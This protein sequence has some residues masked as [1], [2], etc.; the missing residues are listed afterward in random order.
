MPRRTEQRKIRQRLARLHPSQ[1]QSAPAHVS[2]TDEFRREHQLFAEDGQQWLDIFRRSN[3]A[4]KDD[5]TVLAADSRKTLCVTFEE[6]SIAA[7]RRVQL[8]GRNFLQTLQGDDRVRGYQTSTRCDHQ[9]SMEIG[10]HVAKCAGV[11]PLAAKIQATDKTEEFT[12]GHATLAQAHRHLEV[13]I[14]THHEAGANSGDVGGRQKKNPAR[15]EFTI[16]S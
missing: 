3:A 11:C 1:H 8:A 6:R 4:Q 14:L 16:L 10:R 9:G 5:L 15:T 12:Q 2:P 7:I 13:G